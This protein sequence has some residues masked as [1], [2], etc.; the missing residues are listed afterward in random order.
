[1]AAQ[2]AQAVIAVVGLIESNGVNCVNQS[3]SKGYDGA[4][5]TLSGKQVDFLMA[6]MSATKNPMIVVVMISRCKQAEKYFYMAKHSNRT[7]MGKD[8]S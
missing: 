6:I 5:L 2:N 8:I 1:M 3:C 7:V 4:E